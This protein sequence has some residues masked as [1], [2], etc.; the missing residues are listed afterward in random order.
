MPK[1][2]LLRHIKSQWNKEDRFAGWTDGPLDEDQVYDAKKLAQ[3]TLNRFRIDKIYCSALFRN[4]DTVAR[5]FEFGSKKYPMFKH[6]DGGKMQK[7]GNYLTPNND[8]IPVF[9]S[10]K[11]NERYYGKIQGMNKA[12]AAKHFGKDKVHL[13][14]RSYNTAPP[15]GESLKEVV[16]RTIPFY[17]KHIESDLLA[18][19]N[20]LIV[21]SHNSLRAIAKHVEKIPDEEIINYEIAYA[22]L[23]EY[24][25]SKKLKLLGKNVY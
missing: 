7:W 17:I 15:G 25:L 23:I 10:E 4:M 14:R 24:D 20:V 22:G 11:L 9:V 8:E 12:Y 18:G 2:L 3:K 16:K 19:R 13:W 5:M 1:L 21:A 6:L